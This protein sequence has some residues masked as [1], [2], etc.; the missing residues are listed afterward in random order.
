MKIGVDFADDSS[1]ANVHHYKYEIKLDYFTVG[2]AQLLFPFHPTKD[3]QALATKGY[4]NSAKLNTELNRRLREST[5][6][7]LFCVDDFEFVNVRSGNAYL[8]WARSIVK[9]N[10][11]GVKV[12]DYDFSPV[13][14]LKDGYD[15]YQPHLFI[16]ED[17]L[18]VSIT[19]VKLHF[20]GAEAVF[21]CESDLKTRPKLASLRVVHDSVSES[22]MDLAIEIDSDAELDDYLSD[23]DL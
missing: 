23:E 18:K 12:G 3:G 1:C 2:D 22:M 10:I 15:V 6:R 8:L 17:K 7:S 20:D 11:N 9:R 21:C 16:F 19:D 14:I 5:D 4:R 13:L